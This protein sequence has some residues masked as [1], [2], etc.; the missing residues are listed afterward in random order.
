MDGSLTKICPAVRPFD[1]DGPTAE[2]SLTSKDP[3]GNSH[4]NLLL[5]NHWANC[6]QTVVEWSLDGPLQN[7]YP[8]ILTSYQDG[9]PA[10]H[11]KKGG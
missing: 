2:L 11:R 10:E 5:R 7:L 4:K 1:Q 9:R 3:M 6:N 8:V